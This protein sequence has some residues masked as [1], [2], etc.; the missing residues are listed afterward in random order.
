[1]LEAIDERNG[2]ALLQALSRDFFMHDFYCNLVSMPV[3][4]V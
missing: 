4:A 3:S 2:I 1:M